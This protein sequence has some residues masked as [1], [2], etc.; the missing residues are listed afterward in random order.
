MKKL[1]PIFSA[2]CLM[3]LGIG[4]MQSLIAVTFDLNFWYGIGAIIV[5]VSVFLSV[6]IIEIE[7]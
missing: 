6:W 4:L 1:N 2:C 3:L 5:A 7:K